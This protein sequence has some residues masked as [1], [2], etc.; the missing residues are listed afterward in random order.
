MG[1][2][3]EDQSQPATSVFKGV[4][5]VEFTTCSPLGLRYG[6]TA[7]AGV[8]WVGREPSALCKT[9]RFGSIW[10]LGDK[11]EVICDD[12]VVYSACDQSEWTGLF[13]FPL[14]SKA[15]KS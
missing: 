7:E 14:G 4:Q 11:K 3:L 8:G 6:N 12:L 2:H 13:I 9:L 1:K 5:D 15:R 10:N